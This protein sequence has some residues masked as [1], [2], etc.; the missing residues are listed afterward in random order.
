M[1]REAYLG[2][3]QVEDLDLGG[4]DL[5]VLEGVDL[6]L[7]LLPLVLRHRTEVALRQ[8]SQYVRVVSAYVRPLNHH[9]RLE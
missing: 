7:Q 5:K 6:L 3:E 1:R 4:G 9:H 2:G 8:P